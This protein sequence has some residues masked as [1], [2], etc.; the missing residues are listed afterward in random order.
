MWF[1]LNLDFI[2]WEDDE[3]NNLFCY[4]TIPILF[5]DFKGTSKRI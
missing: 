4:L 5:L 3:V 1:Y 2:A